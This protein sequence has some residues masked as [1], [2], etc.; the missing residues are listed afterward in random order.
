MG[1]GTC[2]PLPHLSQGKEPS[3]FS[4]FFHNASP[5]EKGALM[6]KVARDATNSQRE[7]IGL[8]PLPTK[9]T[10]PKYLLVEVCQE[11]YDEHGMEGLVSFLWKD[12]N[13]AQ[14][15]QYS[16]ENETHKTQYPNRPEDFVEDG[17][18]YER[19][20]ILNLIENFPTTGFGIDPDPK[21]PFIEKNSLKEE[22]ERPNPGS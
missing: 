12:E 6:L 2:H 19:T 18:Q 17:I 1:C 3:T 7:Q 14:H 20:R 9:G 16:P 5:E 8:P 21:R 15:T 22:I 13:K 11:V 10:R 4:D